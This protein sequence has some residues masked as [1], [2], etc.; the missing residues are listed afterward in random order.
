[1]ATKKKEREPLFVS[2][3]PTKALLDA[4]VRVAPIVIRTYDGVLCY[5]EKSGC[6]PTFAPME[7]ETCFR[8]LMHVDP[9]DPNAVFAFMS[10]HGLL[11]SLH[12]FDLGRFADAFPANGVLDL[13]EG[14]EETKRAQEYM[15]AIY[16]E[17]IERGKVPALTA[18]RRNGQTYVHPFLSITK[19]TVSFREAS[20][21]I[22]SLQ[23]L[24]NVI[25][26]AVNDYR[27]GDDG[28]RNDQHVFMAAE[29]IGRVLNLYST[30]FALAAPMSAF[31][32]DD[33]GRFG[34]GGLLDA[35]RGLPA[36]VALIAQIASAGLAGYVIKACKNCGELKQFGVGRIDPKTGEYVNRDPKSDYCSP[37]CQKAFNRQDTISYTV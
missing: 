3:I 34:A 16:E 33:G 26:D 36:D 18:S 35:G 37:A 15:S 8:G 7:R 6:E 17:G 5:R 23:H 11:R 19:T 27:K 30:S 12:R 29:F 13:Y 32:F 9:E 4:P 22:R 1:M 14:L 24:T 31:V 28:V 20:A 25:K 10:K 21:C 2:R